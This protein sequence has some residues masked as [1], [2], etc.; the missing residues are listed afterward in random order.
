M[1]WRQC[2]RKWQN[3]NP[4]KVLNKQ[5]FNNV[6]KLA[7][8]QACKPSRPT[9]SNGF[10][11][12]RIYP[13]NPAAISPVKMAPS[14][15]WQNNPIGNVTIVTEESDVD[16]TPLTTPI[17]QQETNNADSQPLVMYLSPPKMLL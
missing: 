2:V 10:M 9:I 4:G 15:I 6:F 8:L 12:A 5:L 13:P 1:A 16:T 11:R 14:G 17:I 3:A 7:W